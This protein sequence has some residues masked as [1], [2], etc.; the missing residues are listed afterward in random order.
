VT[1][2]ALLLAAAA[3]WTFNIGGVGAVAT[4][5]ADVDFRLDKTAVW[6]PGEEVTATYTAAGGRLRLNLSIPQGVPL[7]GGRS[8]SYELDLPPGA[9][10]AARLELAP[11]VEL[12][13][14]AS[15]KIRAATTAAGAE[16]TRVE[17]DVPGTARF[18]AAGAAVFNTT[19]YA[20]PTVRVELVAPG[21]TVTLV[22]KE[23][24]KRA[25]E[26]PVAKSVAYPTPA[27]AVAA[28]AAVLASLALWRL[29]KRA[30]L[31]G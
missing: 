20:V 2:L 8:V 1:P 26:P 25:M 29:R 5:T 13:I 15:V 14:Y 11:G 6:I 31:R 24:D 21:L 19:F 16:P 22:E 12:R 9:G 10:N 3:A 18:K 30:E 17:V 27:V 28:S 7:V 4:Y 23:L